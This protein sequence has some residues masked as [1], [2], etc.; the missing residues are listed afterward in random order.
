MNKKHILFIFKFLITSTIMLFFSEVIFAQTTG[1]DQALPTSEKF[2]ELVGEI[3]PIRKVAL[4]TKVAGKLASVP[5][6]SGEFA[7][8]SSPIAVLETRDFELAVDQAQAALEV[9]MAKLKQM[10]VGSRPEEKK[11]AEEQVRQTKANMENAIADLKRVQDL[12]NTGAVSKSTLDAAQARATVTEAQFMA[13]KFQ[14]EIV[15]Q[16]PRIE[17]KEAM[18]AQIKQQEATLK[19]A[20][21]QLEYATLRA[22]FDG[23]VALRHMDEG[24]YVNPQTPIYTFMQMNPIFAAVDCPERLVPKLSKGLQAKITVDA[25]PGKVFIGVLQ[26]IPVL[27]DSKTRTAKAEFIIENPEH[28]LKPGMFARATVSFIKP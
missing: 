11:A 24:A 23:V 10:E 6:F 3:I 14:N 17:D 8:A 15:D 4:G 18:K 7:A 9:S 22:P 13:S 27:I 21:L 26:R 25:L 2:E 5:L 16:G 19:L 20:K 1:T 28:I 12:F